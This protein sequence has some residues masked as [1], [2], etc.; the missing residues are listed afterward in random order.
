MPRFGVLK[1]NPEPD[2]GWQDAGVD[3][4]ISGILQGLG[5]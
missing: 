4:G 3:P 1:S 2:L 5:V